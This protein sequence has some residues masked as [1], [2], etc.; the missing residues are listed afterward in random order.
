MGKRLRGYET[1]VQACR[2]PPRSVDCRKEQRDKDAVRRRTRTRATWGRCLWRGGWRARSALSA[3][4]AWRLG[5]KTATWPEDILAAGQRERRPVAGQAAAGTE[6]SA[7]LGQTG[8][9]GRPRFGQH[10]REQKNWANAVPRQHYAVGLFDVARRRGSKAG[11][12]WRDRTP[13][14]TLR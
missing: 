7:L 3:G 10:H 12:F 14:A 1:R 5:A 2:L 6:E 8:D 11:M 9:L 4:A 13:S